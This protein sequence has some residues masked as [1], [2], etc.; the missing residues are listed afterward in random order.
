MLWPTR[1]WRKNTGKGAAGLDSARVAWYDATK[2]GGGLVSVWAAPTHRFYR[3]T[4]TKRVFCCGEGA[5][6]I[7]GR[8]F[9]VAGTAIYLWRARTQQNNCTFCCVGR[10]ISWRGEGLAGRWKARQARFDEGLAGRWE[11]RRG[12]LGSGWALGSALGAI[13]RGSAAAFVRWSA[14]DALHGDNLASARS[15]APEQEVARR[16]TGRREAARPTARAP[17]TPQQ[18]KLCVDRRKI[19]PDRRKNDFFPP[20]RA[21]CALLAQ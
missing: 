20:V 1:F 9:A 7:L 15:C 6:R 4:P 2:G 21:F 12:T 18:A 13:R 11:V 17:Q 8:L 16:R 10:V 3:P 14:A 19:S 5:Q